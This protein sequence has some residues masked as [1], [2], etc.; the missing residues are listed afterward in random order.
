MSGKT[1]PPP[2]P[3]PPPAVGAVPPP[4]PA[5]AAT[6]P[7]PPP[8]VDHVA[9]IKELIPERCFYD[10]KPLSTEE[11]IE[12]CFNTL[13]ARMPDFNLEQLHNWIRSST[14]IEMNQER[15][16]AQ[17]NPSSD[18]PTDHQKAQPDPTETKGKV[19]AKGSTGKVPMPTNPEQLSAYDR[20]AEYQC[21][22][23]RGLKS[24]LTKTH[25]TSWGAYCAQFGLSEKTGLPED[26]AATPTVAADIPPTDPPTSPDAPPITGPAVQ[27]P[28]TTQPV[29][30]DPAHAGQQTVMVDFASSVPQMSIVGGSIPA[31]PVG[32][33]LALIPAVMMNQGVPTETLLAAL[34]AYFSY[35]VDGVGPGEA[36]PTTQVAMWLA[37]MRAQGR[38]TEVPADWVAFVSQTA[39]APSPDNDLP[40]FTPPAPAP[41]STAD[42]VQA[43]AE[44]IVTAAAEAAPELVQQAQHLVAQ[45]EDGGQGIAP[46]AAS[47]TLSGPGTIQPAAPKKPSETR[48]AFVAPL[49]GPV[50]LMII[51]VNDLPN[52]DLSRRVDVNALVGL[53]EE[54]GL[55]QVTDPE[56]LKYRE[57]RRV[58]QAVFSKYLCDYKEL[59]VIQNGFNWILPD[60]FVAILMRRVVSGSIIKQGKITPFAL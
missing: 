10:G 53:A 39:P 19:E 8:Q 29:Q 6:P 40:S 20:I 51:N 50:D 15:V 23:M 37:Q 49:G 43:G 30:P 1:P 11:Q 52:V 36:D 33:A 17:S 27:P 25:E 5:A 56:R 7:P 42:A 45:L 32:E 34:A 18:T 13:Q 2:P 26:A 59:F 31:D 21:K 54:E 4:P 3:P 22:S 24:R 44:A 16:P 57:D 9:A 46:P 60:E 47:G 14:R 55:R 28:P 12:W 38:I 41:A 48:L 58:A 35:V